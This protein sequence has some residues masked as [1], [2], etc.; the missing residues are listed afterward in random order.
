[1]AQDTQPEN[2]EETTQIEE[3]EETT[4]NTTAQEQTAEEGQVQALEEELALSKDSCLRMAAEYDNYR[5]RTQKEMEQA[6]QNAVANTVQ[7]FLEVSD[8]LGRAKEAAAGEAVQA[9]DIQKGLHMIADMFQGVFEKLAVEEINPLGEVFH[10]SYH[11]AVMHVD[12]ESAGENTVVEV[13]QKGYKIG[14]R[15][16]RYAMVKV[17]N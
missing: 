11:N 17:A 1:M 12:D 4:D 5:K 15:V 6:Y 9:E 3:I 2:T 7:A 8:N 14:E 13:F 16:L 10:P